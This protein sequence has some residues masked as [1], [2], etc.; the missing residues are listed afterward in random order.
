MSGSFVIASVFDVV[1]VGFTS[2]SVE[3]RVS[4]GACA[5]YYKY[6]RI[7]NAKLSIDQKAKVKA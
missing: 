1:G 7:S 6:G 5:G 3:P 4:Q 2:H